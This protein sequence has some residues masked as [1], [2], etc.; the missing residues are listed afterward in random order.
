METRLYTLLTLCNVF[1]LICGLRLNDVLFI[2]A[3]NR[4]V[5]LIFLH[6]SRG[7]RA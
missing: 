4:F 2:E 6:Q 5:G 7:Y 3:K 1:L